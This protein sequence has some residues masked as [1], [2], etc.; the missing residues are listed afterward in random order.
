LLPQSEQTRRS[1]AFDFFSDDQM[2]VL[3]LRILILKTVDGSLLQ[4]Q[5]SFLRAKPWSLCRSAHAQE[6][7]SSI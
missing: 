6:A 1:T 3:S 4:R 5:K 2:P 7:K